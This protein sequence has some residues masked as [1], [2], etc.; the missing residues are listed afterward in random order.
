M[1]VGVCQ[2]ERH[3][4]VGWRLQGPQIQKVNGIS[5]RVAQLEQQHTAQFISCRRFLV[6]M[7]CVCLC[8]VAVCVC[9]NKV[10]SV[11]RGARCLYIPPKK[12]PSVFCQ[13][14]ITNKEVEAMQ[15]GGGAGCCGWILV[16]VD[17]T[18]GVGLGGREQ[19]RSERLRGKWVNRLVLSCASPLFINKPGGADGALL[20]N[21]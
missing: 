6:G 7:R 14:V 1:R 20:N 16:A 9:T 3:R 19:E 21:A 12:P 10:F 11:Y 18:R 4:E 17:N 13:G 8:A 2:K 15:G 5:G